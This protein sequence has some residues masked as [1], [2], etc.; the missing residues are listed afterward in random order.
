M[1][2]VPMSGK[3]VGSKLKKINSR[4]QIIFSSFQQDGVTINDFVEAGDMNSPVRDSE[5]AQFTVI[6]FFL[7]VFN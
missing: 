6:Y 3:H 2:T 1:T 5:F 7:T 4:K